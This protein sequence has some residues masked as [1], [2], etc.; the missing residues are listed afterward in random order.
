ML[1][2]LVFF[3][4][5]IEVSLRQERKDQ[6]QRII[7]T[8]M[9]IF[10][11]FY[12]LEL[13]G[14]LDQATAQNYAME[15]LENALFGLNG[16]FWINDIE[17]VILMHPYRKDL[18]NKKSIDLMDSKGDYI[19]KSFVSTAIDGGGWVEYFWPLPDGNLEE[20][21]KLSYVN[22]FKPWQWILGTGLYLD[23]MKKEI[24]KTAI[25]AAAYIAVIFTILI[26]ISIFFSK[27]FMVQLKNIAIYD[28]LTS[29]YT[30]HYLNELVPIILSY[31]E[32]N[33]DNFFCAAMFDIDFFKKINDKYGH[34]CGDEV[35]STVA[36]IITSTVR[37]KDFCIRYGGEEFLILTLC[38]SK[39]EAINMVERIRKLTSDK[40]FK[41]KYDSFS[42]TFS[43]G[44][45]YREKDEAFESLVLRADKNLYKAKN[46]GRNRVVY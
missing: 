3:I 14:N 17:G 36:S 10:E 37:K 28:N 9:G 16:Y 46:T 42:V 38:K 15:S 40:V 21:R 43:A 4:D 1:I 32:R 25:N 20:Y 12:S 31:H 27:K 11:Y 44:M 5:A 45:A 41:S 35:L 8:G 29:L 39:I 30:R 33:M 34:V 22:Y 18:V 6:T 2:I 26:I 13:T 7:D 24:E 19:V 23:D